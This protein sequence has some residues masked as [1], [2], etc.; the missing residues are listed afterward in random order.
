LDPETSSKDKENG[1]EDQ[2]VDKSE[3]W[4]PL[5]CLL[6]AASRT[7]SLKSGAHTNEEEQNDNTNND[8]TAMKFKPPKEEKQPQEE[9]NTGPSCSEQ[10]MPVKRK[11]GIRRKKERDTPTRPMFD[12]I[13]TV[14]DRRVGPIWF[15]LVATANRY[16][17]LVSQLN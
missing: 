1:R 4:K 10:P 6:E 16:T 17:L 5:N 12:S 2:Q 11:K 13:S 3:L 15:S 14:R 8:T 7:K 9:E